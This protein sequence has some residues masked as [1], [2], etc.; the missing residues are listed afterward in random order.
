[1]DMLKP[2]IEQRQRGKE[3]YEESGN[4]RTETEG[5]G[6]ERKTAIHR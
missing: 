4:E 5:E 3:S 6:T 1:M 2:K